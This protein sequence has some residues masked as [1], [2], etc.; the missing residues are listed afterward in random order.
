MRGRSKSQVFS[1]CDDV[2]ATVA[3]YE[4]HEA[5]VAEIE[6]K[7]STCYRSI[8]MEDMLSNET[9]WIKVNTDAQHVIDML[10]TVLPADL[11]M[12]AGHNKSICWRS[13]FAMSLGT[14]GILRGGIEE[15]SLHIQVDK[16]E[17]FD[18]PRKY[19]LEMLKRR[20]GITEKRGL[21]QTVLC[22][23]RVYLAGFPKSGSTALDDILTVHPNINHGLS[24]EPRWWVP[25]QLHPNSHPFKAKL[26]YFVKY[27]LQYQYK[28]MEGIPSNDILLLDSSPNLLA[29]WFNIGQNEEYE[30]VCLLPTVISTLIPRPQF[31]TILRD[32]IEYLYSNFWFRCSSKVTRD[33]NLTQLQARRGPLVF[34]AL[35]MKRLK[36]FKK[37]LK[38]TGSSEERCVL[39]QSLLVDKLDDYFPCGQVS[40]GKAVYYVHIL[41]WLSLFPRGSFYFVTSEEFFQSPF[42]VALEVWEF[43]GVPRSEMNY[44][45]LNQRMERGENI[46]VRFDYRRDRKLQ[47]LARTR[48]ILKKFFKPFNARL[49]MLLSSE[50]RTWRHA[51]QGRHKYPEVYGNLSK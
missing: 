31:I 21:Y 50:K 38:K 45:L 42:T 17:S 1:R 16:D 30:G 39:E 10:Q 3:N 29:T 36:S 13:T 28:D 40:L 12:P 26:E 23:P 43:L 15:Y 49:S 35:L 11:T 5:L 46:Q 20:T 25:P 8:H 48:I 34:H 14:D 19:Y 18:D 9:F 44:E 6:R 27:I 33:Y 37:C 32:P 22:I 2:L 47:M 51:W 41:R 7:L 4:E 24:K